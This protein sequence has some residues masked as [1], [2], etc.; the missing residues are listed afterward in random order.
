MIDV[1]CLTLKV[2]YLNSNF[3]VKKQLVTKKYKNSDTYRSLENNQTKVRND[4]KIHFI[5]ISW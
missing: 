3:K 5:N 4:I 2:L 1:I